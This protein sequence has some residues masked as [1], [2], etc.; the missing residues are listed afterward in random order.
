MKRQIISILLALS[1]VS[2]ANAD[3]VPIVIPSGQELYFE[4]SSLDGG[5]AVVVAPYK[6]V[7]YDD[8]SY[9]WNGYAKPGGDVVIPDTVMY[10]GTKYA[11]RYIRQNAFSYC[12]AI[13]S[14][15]VPNTVKSI[16][17]NA[18]AHCSSLHVLTIGNNV[19]AIGYSHD[20]MYNSSYHATCNILS[21]N[22]TIDT[23]YYDADSCMGRIF[24]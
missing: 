23:I 13:T 17:N 16:G 20:G 21:G 8:E 12:T 7:A 6:S 4:F 24:I 9:S 14:I 22:L 5:Y 18:F 19:S 15:V 1:V 10:N 3:G 2:I 11:V